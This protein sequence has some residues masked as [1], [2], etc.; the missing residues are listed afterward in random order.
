MLKNTIKMIVVVL[1]MGL[2]ASNGYGSI[3]EQEIHT[4]F[5]VPGMRLDASAENRVR[6]GEKPETYARANCYATIYQGEI[7]FNGETNYYSLDSIGGSLRT[8]KWDTSELEFQGFAQFKLLDSL[9][10]VT[11]QPMSSSF[12]FNLSGLDISTNVQA[13]NRVKWTFNT[14]DPQQNSGYPVITDDIEV[15]FGIQIS[16]AQINRIRP[17]VDNLL[18]TQ[19]ENR[20]PY[21][22]E[23][24]NLSFTAYGSFLA[25]TPEQADAMGAGFV[26]VVPEPVTMTLMGLGGLSLLRR[27]SAL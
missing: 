16:N 12:S 25:D 22:Q 11:C 21:T 15:S 8:N 20:I 17:D 3:V 13:Q 10:E 14:Q 2:V 6:G 27:R 23:F 5:N 18:W 26:E 24:M 9:P 1:V 4:G 7:D 19:W